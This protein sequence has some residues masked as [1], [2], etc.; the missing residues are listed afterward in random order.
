MIESEISTL[1]DSSRLSVAR[2]GVIRDFINAVCDV[3]PEVSVHL[4]DPNWGALE[5]ERNGKSIARVFTKSGKVQIYNSDMGRSANYFGEDIVC[6][7]LN[8][9]VFTV[10]QDSDAERMLSCLSENLTARDRPTVRPRSSSLDESTPTPRTLSRRLRFAVLFRDGFTCQYCGRKPP[11][12][13]L[14]IDHRNP[15]SLGGEHSMENLLAACSECNLGK[16]NKFST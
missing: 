8:Q 13:S 6:N 1:V 3:D 14:H 16:S 5:I 9:W 11:E 12:V 10:K 2:K 7:D 15:V 4:G